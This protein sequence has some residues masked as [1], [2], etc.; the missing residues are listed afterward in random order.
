MT[1]LRSY[2]VLSDIHLGARNTPAREILAN[3]SAFFDDFSDKSELAKVDV[4]FIAG[5]L[6]E[7][8][9]DFASEV[10][11]L[12]IRWFVPMLKWCERNHI[13]LR[14][15]E[16]TPRHDRKQS[17]TI[18]N[19]AKSIASKADFKYVPLL[20]IEKMD[21]LDLSIL[22]V[23]DE[24]RP[25]SD[26]VE[27]DTEALL[28]EEGLK[29][30]DIA[31]MHGMFKYQLGTIPMNA[32]VYDELW[33]LDHVKGYINI[34]HIHQASQHGRIVAQGSFDRLA[35]GEE[36]PKGASL[37]KEVCPG[38]WINLFIENKLAKVYRSVKISG[39]IEDALKKIDKLAL[40]IPDG[41]FIRVLGDPSHPLFQGFE[42][43]RQKYPTITFSSKKTKASKSEEV[44]ASA[45]IDYR[46]I[47]LNR[48]TLTEAIYSEASLSNDLTMD[49]GRKLHALLESL[50]T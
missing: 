10:I 48:E 42:T 20:S 41:S 21:D 24:C 44:E 14:I 38:E 50:H 16:G 33:F 5:D 11:T 6:W 9:I 43:L 2:L 23:P 4:I 27:R 15:L 39:T 45:P 34:G 17:A 22:Y 30:V 26:V 7:D 28:V 19:L 25:T 29:R 8:T 36:S 37:I 3:L 31:I 40:S 49:D 13:K 18:L 12:F 32:K 47:I 35:H 46:A 1:K